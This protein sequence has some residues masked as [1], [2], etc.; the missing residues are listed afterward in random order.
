MYHRGATSGRTNWIELGGSPFNSIFI[1]CTRKVLAKSDFRNQILLT[2][3]KKF[4][5]NTIVTVGVSLE[6]SEL[7]S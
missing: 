1:M 5:D 3:Y 2:G 7:D 4:R 6:D